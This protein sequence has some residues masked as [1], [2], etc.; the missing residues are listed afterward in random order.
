MGP[1]IRF[2]LGVTDDYLKAIGTVVAYWGIFESIL[3]DIIATMRVL[4]EAKSVAEKIPPS[5]SGRSKL[6]VQMATVCFSDSQSLVKR[7]DDMIV[8]A[9]RYSI[10]RNRIVHASWI[11]GGEDPLLLS[12]HKLE[13][14]PY[15]ATLED[16][17][18]LGDDI[19]DLFVMFMRLLFRVSANT[20]PFL[21]RDEMAVVD[22]FWTRV[23]E[24]GGYH[25]DRYGNA[26]CPS[27][28]KI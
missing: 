14:K 2:L 27:F 16:V 8:L 11:A 5:F 15:I 26:D 21:T 3:D 18:S 17:R 23:A 10:Q 20:K 24:Q 13:L 25:S 12:W 4:P 7:C 6:F 22:A 1:P 9:K 19:H 28:R